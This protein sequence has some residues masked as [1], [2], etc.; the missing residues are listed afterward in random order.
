[1]ADERHAA[2]A[3]QALA[4]ADNIQNGNL[5]DAITDLFDVGDPEDCVS[6]ALRA[7]VLLSDMNENKTPEQV[8]ELLVRLIDRWRST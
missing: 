2:H 5:T 8:A 1:M 4:I 6:V 3:R 7:L